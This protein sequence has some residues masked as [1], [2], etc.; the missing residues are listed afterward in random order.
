ME[1]QPLGELAENFDD[2]TVDPGRHVGQPV[3]DDQPL[4]GRRA[5][6]GAA[7]G[8]EEHQFAVGAGPRNMARV[9]VH[10]DQGI[11]VEKTGIQ[12]R[13]EGIGEHV[14]GAAE[15]VVA[16]RR[17][18]DDEMAVAEAL[19][20]GHQPRQVLVDRPFHP[21]PRIEIGKLLVESGVLC[22]MDVSDGLIGDLEKLARAS[23]VG[24]AVEMADVPVP[25]E[26][27]FMFGTRAID[28]AL[29]GG[30]DYELVFTTTEAIHKT[31]SSAL[32]PDIKVIGRVTEGNVPTGEVK[33][34]DATGAVYEPVHK[35]W[36]HL[37][38]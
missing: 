28:L 30:E 34:F 6:V 4:D 8:H 36:D 9:A 27:I 37:D 2:R 26:L 32:G 15:H 31:L 33:V 16:A 3:G 21:T 29:G 7:F 17:I 1:S 11:E 10:P 14:R 12:G 20:R 18:D 19:Q 5:H 38:G 25:T 24:I 23:N 22:A 13:D 35:G